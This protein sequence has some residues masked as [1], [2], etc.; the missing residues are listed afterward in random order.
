MAG[1]RGLIV[2]AMVAASV[3]TLT[4]IFNSCTTLFTLDIWSKLR[5]RASEFELLFV[6]RCFV[7]VA[8]ALSVVLIPIMKDQAGGQIFFYTTMLLGLLG[9]PTCAGLILAIFWKRTNEQ[10]LDDYISL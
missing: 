1:L 3:S 9:A 2:A 7:V 5:P 8:T 6:G 4:S 10:V